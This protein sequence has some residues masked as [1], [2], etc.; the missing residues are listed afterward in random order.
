MSVL[1][2]DT[3][4]NK[5][6]QHQQELHEEGILHLSLFGSVARGQ[7]GPGSDVDLVAEFDPAK[8]Y[9]ILDRVR[10]ENRLAAILGASVDLAPQTALLDDVRD[11]ALHESIRAF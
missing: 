10:L 2:K 4:L 7:S 11:R 5:L 9:S 3:L 1:D 6:R 8:R